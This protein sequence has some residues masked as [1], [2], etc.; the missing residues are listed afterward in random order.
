MLVNGIEAWLETRGRPLRPLVPALPPDVTYPDGAPPRRRLHGPSPGRP[1]PSASR[2]GPRWRRRSSRSTAPAE[3][4][5]RWRRTG[6]D[7]PARL[8]VRPLL[9]G[10][11]YHALHH[12]N[13]ALRFDA[14]DDAATVAWRPYPG[15]PADRGVWPT[16]SYRTSRMVPQFLYAEE[17]ERGLDAIEDLASPGVLHVRPRGGDASCAARRRRPDAGAALAATVDRGRP[18]GRAR[19]P[20]RLRVAAG[21]APPTPTRA[22]RRRAARSSP[23]IP[24]SP[25]GAATPSSPCAAS[26]LIDRR[27]RARRA[28]I[29]LAVGG[30]V[31]EGM[32]PNR[33]PDVGRD[34]GVQLG[35]RVALVRR[36]GARLPAGA[37]RRRA[38]ARARS[39]RARAAVA[40]ILDGYAA[41]HALRH[42]D[43]TRT[44]CSRPACRACSSPGWTPRSATGWSRRGSA[45]RS[46]S[47]RCG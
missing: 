28:T 39:R 40:A 37:A 29:L 42:P 34:A 17:E 41:R 15:V 35:R 44:A 33:F 25:T 9:S 47:R 8:V 12:E 10:R 32:L 2:T 18:R 46:R 36:R 16:A 13:P 11:D 31:C 6:G 4:V 43:A 20:R 21:T 7:G 5:L 23:A 3:V 14:R 38:A 30:A 45:S 22:P 24:G 19:P 26:C 27:R 1:G